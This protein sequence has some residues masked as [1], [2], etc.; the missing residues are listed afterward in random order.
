[1]LPA[2]NHAFGALNQLGKSALTVT[3]FLIGNLISTYIAS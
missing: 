1:M 3:L 2:W